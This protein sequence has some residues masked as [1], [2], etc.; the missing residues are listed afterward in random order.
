[1]LHSQQAIN[2]S[3][4]RKNVKRYHE[5]C[6][7]HDYGGPEQIK[8]EQV[9]RPEPQAGQVLV[10]L[11]AIGVNPADWKM[12]SGY[13]QKFMPLSMPWIPGLEGSGII[14]AVGPGVTDFKKGQKVFGAFSNSYAEYVVAN[15][16][17]GFFKP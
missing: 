2:K 14:E 11:Y 10:R 7:I 16:K 4:G 5:S 15:S 12:R 9:E 8:I 3:I 6:R 13:Y 17:R 1:M